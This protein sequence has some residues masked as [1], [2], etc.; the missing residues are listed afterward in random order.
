MYAHIL[1]K[2]SFATILA[3]LLLSTPTVADNFDAIVKEALAEGNKASDSTPAGGSINDNQ[4]PSADTGATS[5][6]TTK[7]PSPSAT[8]GGGDTQD[9]QQ[10]DIGSMGKNL[11]NPNANSKS[12]GECLSGCAAIVDSLTESCKKLSDPK[13]GS[14]YDECDQTIKTELDG[15]KEDC[16]TRKDA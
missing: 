4:P 7:Q 6:D 8:S 2:L 12:Y 5:E 10:P 9:Q 15:C 13:K 14:S 16:K 11:K 1:F 3:L